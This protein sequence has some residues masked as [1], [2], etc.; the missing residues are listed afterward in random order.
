MI[1]WDF[2]DFA[3]V[4]Q[5]HHL[6][7]LCYYLQHPSH[8]SPQALQKAKNILKDVIE[9]NFSDKDIYQKE[10]D[11]FSSDKRKW[12]VEGTTTNH[13]EYGSDIHW[14]MTVY[15]VVKDGLDRYPENVKKWA[16][17]I[18]EDIKQSDHFL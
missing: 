5:I 13:G 1:A 12:S 2:S 17:T 14:K 4:G 15:E 11:V 7:V 6:T 18:Y 3:E 10:S 16:H 9:K 8:Y